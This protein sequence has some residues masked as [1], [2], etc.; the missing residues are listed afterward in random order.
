MVAELLA[1][2]RRGAAPQTP[3]SSAEPRRALALAR[4]PLFTDISDSSD[5][6]LYVLTAPPGFETVDMP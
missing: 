3:A 6:D 4:V 2:L 1:A 5:I